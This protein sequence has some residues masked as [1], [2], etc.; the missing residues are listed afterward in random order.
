MRVRGLLLV[1]IIAMSALL[2]IWVFV[3]FSPTSTYRPSYKGCGVTG[4]GVPQ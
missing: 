3:M 4:C 1:S 2:I